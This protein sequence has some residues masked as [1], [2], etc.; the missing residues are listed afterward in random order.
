MSTPSFTS[1]EEAK[2]WVQQNLPRGVQ[3][4]CCGQHAKV[5]KRKL[6]PTMACALIGIYRYFRDNPSEP[7]LH[8]PDFLVKYQT[9]AKI[10]GGD[11]AKLRFWDVLDAKSSLSRDQLPDGADRVGYYKITDLGKAFVERRVAI[12]SCVY[13]YNQM[14]LRSSDELTTIEQALGDRYDYRDLLTYQPVTDERNRP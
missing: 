13:L 14:L 1:L 11:V 12:P 10:A 9:D 7:W 6:N 5:Y 8:V 4:P 2:A 3:C